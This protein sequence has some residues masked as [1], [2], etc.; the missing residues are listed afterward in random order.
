MDL[1]WLIFLIGPLDLI[2]TKFNEDRRANIIKTHF[3]K[4]LD[5]IFRSE[6]ITTL[7]SNGEH[8]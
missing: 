6:Y 4:R 1:K 7:N 5:Y 3:Q 8:N 2:G